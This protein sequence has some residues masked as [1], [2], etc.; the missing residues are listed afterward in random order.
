M[1]RVKCLHC[2]ASV[3]LA[4]NGSDM[5]DTAYEAMCPLL[6]RFKGPGADCWHMRNAIEADQIQLIKARQRK[7]R[8]ARS[9][10]AVM[11]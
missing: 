9:G 6:G 11:R 1:M 5:G 10:T 7:R 8:N 2:E 3:K 4:A